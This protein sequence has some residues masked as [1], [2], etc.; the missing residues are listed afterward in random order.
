LI[1]P[2]CGHLAEST[3]FA[4]VMAMVAFWMRG[5]S[6]AA[7]Y[8]VWFGGAAKFAVPAAL[9]AQ[10]GVSL[11]MFLPVRY[12]SLIQQANL[13]SGVYPQFSVAA[14]P[15]HQWLVPVVLTVWLAGL[16][17]MFSLWVRRSRAQ[18]H[19]LEDAGPSEQSVLAKLRQRAGVR[20][21]VKLRYSSPGRC[22]LGLWGIRRPTIRIPRGLSSQLTPTE[23]EAVLL[24]ELAHV[25]R[26]DN[27]SGA[28][29]HLL[30]CVFW[31]HPL[32]WWIERRLLVERERACDEFVIQTGAPTETYV[33]GILKVCRFQ[34]AEPV[35]GTSGMT[36]S[37][38]QNRLE[39]IMSYRPKS[40]VPPMRRLLP[41][42]LAAVMTIVPFG[43]GLLRS[44]HA[45]VSGSACFVDS[46]R[47]SQGSVV[48]MAGITKECSAGSWIPTN[49]TATATVRAKP[50]FV[51][52]IRPSQSSNACRCQD[53]DY[54]LG[55]IARTSDNSFIRCDRFELGKFT[56]WR[57]ATSRELGAR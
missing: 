52:E 22:E 5:R 39:A 34:L 2:L 30:L 4:T 45:S 31:F 49:K 3:I 35:A 29:V 42:A 15:S 56:A 19:S 14:D 57:P 26:R 12:S 46:V 8:I 24:H 11:E 37:N 13:S 21:A 53:G 28:F 41:V 44:A 43:G 50:Q 51:C 40:S 33:T 38:L 7:R 47:Y 10:L 54:S 18:P 25:R 48:R 17:A 27:L 32:L 6:A 9:F 36:R 16:V 55:A 23:F 20:K 1:I